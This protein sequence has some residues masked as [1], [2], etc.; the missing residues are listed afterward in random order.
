MPLLPQHTHPCLDSHSPP[1]PVLCEV[2]K[3]QQAHRE[4]CSLEC[5]HGRE[6]LSTPQDLPSTV[7]SATCDPPGQSRSASNHMPHAPLWGSAVGLRKTQTPP[8]S[9]GPEHT[10]PPPPPPHAN[11]TIDPHMPTVGPQADGDAE[12]L[13]C[14][15]ALNP[16][17]A[18]GCA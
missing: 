10:Q 5:S 4:L 2:T 8:A 3:A 13:M 7:C 6:V 1:G 11:N 17:Q 16:P 14:Y 12:T 15:C 18:L 9:L